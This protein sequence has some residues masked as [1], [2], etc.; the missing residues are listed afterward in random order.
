MKPGAREQKGSASLQTPVMLHVQS[1]D[2][3]MG[4]KTKT[5]IRQYIIGIYFTDP[6]AKG[7]RF[8]GATDE[9]DEGN[10]KWMN[11]DTVSFNKFSWFRINN[12]DGD[13]TGMPANCGALTTARYNIIDEYCL[14]E[15]NYLCESA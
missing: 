13:F 1:Q 5:Q 11:G 2:T 7:H 15:H 6:K 9:G 8:V 12:A 10:W 3:T 4:N 14:Q